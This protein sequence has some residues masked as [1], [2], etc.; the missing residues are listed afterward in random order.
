MSE[1]RGAMDQIVDS[2]T[3]VRADGGYAFP[4]AMCSP[5]LCVPGQAPLRRR[6]VPKKTLV[7]RPVSSRPR[8]PPCAS[9]TNAVEPFGCVRQV[10]GRLNTRSQEHQGALNAAP[11]KSGASKSGAIEG[12]FIEVWCI[13]VGASKSGSSKSG[14]SNSGAWKSGAIEVSGAS[15]SGAIEV[16]CHRLAQGV[17]GAPPAH[18]LH[19]APQRPRDLRLIIYPVVHPTRRLRTTHG[20]PAP[21]AAC[22]HPSGCAGMR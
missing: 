8:L 5:R 17:A 9:R 16:R 10:A 15:K 18:H 4:E 6:G 20:A 19:D 11:S 1:S 13:E 2:I 7:C 22:G 3:L 12:W 21:P 14:S